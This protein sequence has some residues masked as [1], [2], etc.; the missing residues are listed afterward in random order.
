MTF[1]L[2]RL[3]RKYAKYVPIE[4]VLISMILMMMVDVNAMAH[5]EL[6]ELD[7]LSLCRKVPSA[8]PWCMGTSEVLF[9]KMYSNNIVE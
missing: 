3:L 1:V 9:V 6:A 2:V 5:D 4:L 7:E 8:R